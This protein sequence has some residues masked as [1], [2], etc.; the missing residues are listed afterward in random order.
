MRRLEGKVAAITGASTGFGRGIA[1]A[2]AREGAKVVARER[3]LDRLVE[4]MPLPWESYREHVQ[5]AVDRIWVTG[6][7]D[8]SRGGDHDHR[9][10]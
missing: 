1:V 7:H 5:R 8:P 10:P 2:F 6:D 3:Q 4:N 9:H